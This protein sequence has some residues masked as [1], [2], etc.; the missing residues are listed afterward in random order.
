MHVFNLPKI[1]L[2]KIMDTSSEIES[3][4]DHFDDPNSGWETGDGESQTSDDDDST[5]KSSYAS[6]L[7]MIWSYKYY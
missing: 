2:L 5:K 7:G 4:E 3:D 6:R 1:F